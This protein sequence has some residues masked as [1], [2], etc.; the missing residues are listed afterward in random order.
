MSRDTFRDDLLAAV[1][2]LRAFAVS[3]THNW[4]AAD[5]LVQDTI[6]R[7]WASRERFEAGT[8]LNAWLFTILRNLF[9]SV[10]RKRVREIEDP[11][12]TY[13][14]GLSTRPDQH[15]HLDFQDMQAALQRL[16]ADQREA[17]LLIAAEGLSYEDAAAIT[18][19]AVGTVKSRVNRAR[20]RLAG[21]LHVEPDDEVGPDGI[22]LAA[23]QR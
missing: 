18:G 7:A 22:T 16:P 3:L 2:S 19:V 10:H 5:D 11:D 14:G 23:L 17:L 6:T 13:A 9:Y 15:A 4:D 20:A 8:N 21:L 1:P 12:G